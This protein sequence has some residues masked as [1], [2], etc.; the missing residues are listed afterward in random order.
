MVIR[1]GRGGPPRAASVQ[2]RQSHSAAPEDEGR[3]RLTLFEAQLWERDG[4][5]YKKKGPATRLKAN[6]ALAAA[7]KFAEQWKLS[8]DN[9]QKGHR[10]LFVIRVEVVN[11][12]VH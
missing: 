7:R 9:W 11:A 6:D 3:E 5:S 8:D 2:S 12:R 1:N 10:P 4:K